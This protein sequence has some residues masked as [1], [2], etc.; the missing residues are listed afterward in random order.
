[1]P[2]WRWWLGFEAVVAFVVAI[3]VTAVPES[4]RWLLIVHRY[5][6]EMNEDCEN[7]AREVVKVRDH[8]TSNTGLQYRRGRVGTGQGRPTN[9]HTHK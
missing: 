9:I 2:V 5:D 1:M 8:S 4:A 6:P 3:L 7:N